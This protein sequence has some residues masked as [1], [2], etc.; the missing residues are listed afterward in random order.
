MLSMIGHS[1]KTSLIDNPEIS[2]SSYYM[3]QLLTFLSAIN[4][5]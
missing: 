3:Y 2:L 4:F 1:L 5:V